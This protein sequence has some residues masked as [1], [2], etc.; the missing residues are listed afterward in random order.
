MQNTGNSSR[1]GIVRVYVDELGFVFVGGDVS[2]P[3]YSS[4]WEGGGT[5]KARD[6]GREEISAC[7]S[8]PV[9]CCAFDSPLSEGAETAG[10]S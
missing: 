5:R 3:R 10:D 7:F 1:W 4:L 2:A 8:P 6:G 9:K